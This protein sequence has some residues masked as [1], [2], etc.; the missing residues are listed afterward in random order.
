MPQVC[1]L[2]VLLQRITAYDKLSG[3][4]SIIALNPAAPA[5]AVALDA[6]LAAAISSGGILPSLFCVPFIIKDL[7]DLVGTASTAG[8]VAFQDNFP[9]QDAHMVRTCITNRYAHALM[10][11]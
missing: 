9:F 3:L 8:S 2:L 7:Y 10:Y 6:Q 11:A 1:S 5:E 4:N